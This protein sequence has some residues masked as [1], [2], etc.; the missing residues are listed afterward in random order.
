MQ[1]GLLVSKHYED[2]N[3]PSTPLPDFNPSNGA[4]TEHPI[5]TLIRNA[6]QSYR[7]KVL[8]QS[9]S[10]KAAVK[11]YQRRYNRPPPRGFKEWWEFAVDN[12]VKMVDEFDS[13]HDDLLP[14]WEI[15][16][17]EFK[18][19][20]TQV[21]AL[22]SIELVRV[23]GGISSIINVYNNYLEDGTSPRSHGFNRMIQKFVHK[24]PDLDFP[25][26]T[27]SEGRVLVAWEDR[28]MKNN[29]NS[30]RDSSGG[31][32]SM[33]GD[34]FVADWQGVG[35]VWDAWRR[36][37][38]P[39]SASRR[40]F[41]SMKASSASN[42][43]DYLTTYDQ[44]NASVSSPSSDFTFARDTSA[45]IN[46]CD[47]P[48]AHFMQ[49]HFFSDWRTIPVLYPVLSP[50]KAPGFL[51]IRIPSHYYYGSTAR[52]TY[53]WDPVNL[54]LGGN[55]RG[56]QPW[57]QKSDKIYW[58]GAST[59]GGNHPSGYSHHYHRH[60]FLRQASDSSSHNRT[61]TF[62]DPSTAQ[63]VSAQVPVS[64]LNAGALD[65]AF[66]AAA[67]GETYYDGPDG[68]RRDHRF[69]N[70]ASLGD[71]WGHKYLLD[72][73]GMGYSGRFMAF[74][75][76][77][78][79]VLKSTVYKEFYSDWIQPW[80]H[81]IPL[82]TSFRE[83]YNIHAYF[84]GPSQD[85]MTATNLTSS[86]RDHLFRQGDRQLRRIARAG[87]HWKKTMG[88]RADMEAYLYRLC[89]EFARLSSDDRDSMNFT[90]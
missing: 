66:V 16:G 76:S 81:F 74:L 37:C 22:P 85:A 25:I 68:L 5:S 13:I 21:G 19:R 53:G 42:V 3:Q 90:L 33:V 54:E 15:S 32:T 10:L 39:G 80:L 18:R 70:A 40:L 12:N 23:R 64:T 38:S 43:K 71:H 82:T 28:E 7:S 51:D 4:V 89:L 87:K 75:A 26:N 83:I 34:N 60:R 55:D 57:D 41:S 27:R 78:S 30:T 29:K 62:L 9:Q 6:E 67:D 52:Y 69:G 45:H 79:A 58:R 59:G 35:S 46:F 49:G 72:L 1:A 44:P 17:E 88:R 20:A 14:F 65:V 31:P 61:V 56:E 24:L 77:D 47:K 36:T 50:G 84:S 63:A 2:F 86:H 8:R 11:E 73:D 48:H